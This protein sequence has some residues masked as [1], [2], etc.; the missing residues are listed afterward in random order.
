[1]SSL[2]TRASD[3]TLRLLGTTDV[4][5]V[6][7]ATAK[8]G[9]YSQGGTVLIRRHLELGQT[10]SRA[11]CSELGFGRTSLSSISLRTGGFGF[12]GVL[13]VLERNPRKDIPVVIFSV[14]EDQRDMQR[15]LALGAR[16]YVQKPMNLEAYKKAVLG[17]IEKWVRPENNGAEGAAAS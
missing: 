2:L 10:F 15:A 17:I 12:C 1:M 5:R 9:K 13:A 7:P 4:P 14:S 16:E 6:K 11:S 8:L 3:T